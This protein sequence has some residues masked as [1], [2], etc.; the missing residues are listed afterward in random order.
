MSGKKKLFELKKTI[1]SWRK[2]ATS[3]A[4][5]SWK[6]LTSSYGSSQL[7]SGLSLVNSMYVF[8]VLFLL[9]AYLKGK[10]KQI[11][12]FPWMSWVHCK[13][14]RAWPIHVTGLLNTTGMQLKTWHS[15]VSFKRL[16]HRTPKFYY[17]FA[18]WFLNLMKETKSKKFRS[19]SQLIYCFTTGSKI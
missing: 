17:F 11:H 6:S 1:P 9:R 16:N 3:R 10:S 19:F 14:K 13:R 4:E 8:S 5:P 7:G 15:I 2:K 12:R 18:S